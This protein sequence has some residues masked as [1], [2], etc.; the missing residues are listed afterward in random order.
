MYWKK[1]KIYK[2]QIKSGNFH[3]HI[4]LEA[5]LNVPLPS[6]LL[7]NSI[8]HSHSKRRHDLP[9][10][11]IWFGLSHVNSTTVRSDNK[12]C[13]SMRGVLVFG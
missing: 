10:F 12:G 3:L 8:T 6:L 5:S 13:K 9:T 1:S 4:S 11:V 7:K 2:K